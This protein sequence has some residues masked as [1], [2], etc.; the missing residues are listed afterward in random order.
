M[1]KS[2]RDLFLNLPFAICNLHKKQPP[3]IEAAAESIKLYSVLRSA[4]AISATKSLTVITPYASTTAVELQ[5]SP[6][7]KNQTVYS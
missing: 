2:L 5:T 1:F 7:A 3:R 6:L 4:Y